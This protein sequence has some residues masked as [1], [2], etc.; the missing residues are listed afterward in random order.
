MRFSLYFKNFW[1]TCLF[2]SVICNEFCALAK[3]FTRDLNKRQEI[4]KIT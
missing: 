4:K 1:I 2:T 3:S